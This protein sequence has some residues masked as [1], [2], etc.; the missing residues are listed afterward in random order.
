M[1]QHFGFKKGME[2]L[3]TLLYFSTN[4]KSHIFLIIFSGIFLAPI[5]NI[6]IS[7]NSATYLFGAATF[8]NEGY[9]PFLKEGLVARGPIYT[10][11][12]S[13]SNYLADYNIIAIFYLQKLLLSLGLAWLIARYVNT[14][15]QSVLL[16]AFVYANYKFLSY[17]FAIDTTGLYSLLC[18]FLFL[19]ATNKT[20][21]DDATII[22]L[23]LLVA[24]LFLTK[25]TGLFFGVM[26]G[27]Y[28]LKNRGLRRA[29]YYLL[30][31][32]IL[33]IP[34]IIYVN[35]QGNSLWA[36]L[37]HF[38]PHYLAATVHDVTENK[39]LD[40]SIYDTVTT[41]I[42]KMFVQPYPAASAFLFV[43]LSVKFY[44][45][46]RPIQVT[47]K[48]EVCASTSIGILLLFVSMILPALD[49]LVGGADPRQ[50]A[51]TIMICMIVF[52]RYLSS[53]NK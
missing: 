28:I 43:F 39:M 40:G 46:L 48:R 45:L 37:G 31:V 2:F 14:Y 44:R 25:E 23:G 52:G 30:A 41:L 33:V 16:L 7:N 21:F 17:S 36:I 20:W 18:G 9:I 13:A 50:S 29:S 8:L 38:N 53:R 35:L 5:H 4:R 49:F 24:L 3:K 12:L 19:T 6:Y 47:N 1:K 10:V 42:T 32:F 26:I 22:K 34:W 11:F 15:F 27:L 51:A